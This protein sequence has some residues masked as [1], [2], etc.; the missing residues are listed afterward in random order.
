MLRWLNLVS[1]EWI[2]S[3]A[4]L[5]VI[6]NDIGTL[7]RRSTLGDGYQLIKEEETMSF[8]I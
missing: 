8:Y 6:C 4:R 5:E 3:E 1:N 7:A 2:D